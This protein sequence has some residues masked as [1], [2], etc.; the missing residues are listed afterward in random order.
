MG[1]TLKEMNLLLKK[2]I[3]SFK[4]W[5]PF[6]RV[7]KLEMADLLLV[8]VPVHLKAEPVTAFVM[9]SELCGKGRQ[10]LSDFCT[11]LFFLSIL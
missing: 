4:S 8:K 5:P 10:Y 6:R 2:Q 7:V 11:L 1:I 9:R 3:L